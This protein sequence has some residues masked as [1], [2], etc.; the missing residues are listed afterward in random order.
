MCPETYGSEDEKGEIPQPRLPP[1]NLEELGPYSA[2]K[3]IAPL[4]P[5]AY[6]M[7]SGAAPHSAPPRAHRCCLAS[8]PSRATI[9]ADSPGAPAGNIQQEGATVDR[10]RFPTAA[11]EA[12]ALE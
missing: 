12:K 10:C 11:A 4:I 2:N 7:L 8:A 5:M 9:R 1:P 6:S 3:I